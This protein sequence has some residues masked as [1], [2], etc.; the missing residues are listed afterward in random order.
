MVNARLSN[1][2][3][4]S[5]A[6]DSYVEV[7]DDVD[8]VESD[9]DF[10]SE[11]GRQ[12]RLMTSYITQVRGFNAAWQSSMQ[13]QAQA[14][15]RSTT[16]VTSRDP[17]PYTRPSSPQPQHRVYNLR[18]SHCDNFVSD[19]G[20]RAV[21][22]LR[23]H[24]TLFSTD[25]PPSNCGALYSSMD[26]EPLSEQEQVERTCDCLTQSLGCFGCGN[27]IG[28]KPP[29]TISLASPTKSA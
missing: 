4:A 11:Q 7:H 17:P 19:R 5:Q 22:L 25:A 3:S 23:P 2:G 8:V 26:E 27:V 1:D 28:C 10:T 6:M 24:I 14:H 18:C 16:P 9:F 21:L 15:S 20:M 12:H 29:S 13:W